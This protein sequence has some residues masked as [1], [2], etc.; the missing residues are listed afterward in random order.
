MTPIP[1]IISLCGEAWRLYDAWMD[2]LT[3]NV[4]ISDKVQAAHNAFQRH[5]QECPDCTPHAWYQRAKDLQTAFPD[6]AEQAGQKILDALRGK[7]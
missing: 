7:P 5:R 1:Q 3:G 2:A 4:L 6:T